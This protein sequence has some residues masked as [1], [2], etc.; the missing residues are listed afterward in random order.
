MPP[1]VGCADGLDEG[2]RVGSSFTSMV[3]VVHGVGG[4]AGGHVVLRNTITVS[5]DGHGSGTA[6]GQGVA[7]TEGASVHG[8]HASHG[9]A[10]VVLTAGGHVGHSSV[11]VLHGA[12]SVGISS[13]FVVHGHAEQS[14][15]GAD[16]G[17]GAGVDTC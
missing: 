4:G 3:K 6:T 10:V 13:P 2:S 16:V 14:V 17:A 5:A 8:S 7:G 12:S 15:V 11:S 1:C 9:A